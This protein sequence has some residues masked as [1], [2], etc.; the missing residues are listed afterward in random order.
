MQLQDKTLSTTITK[1]IIAPLY[2]TFIFVDSDYLLSSEGSSIS[3]SVLAALNLNKASGL[4]CG[5]NSHFFTA[6]L[7]AHIVLVNHHYP[8]PTPFLHTTFLELSLIYV[9]NQLF[10]TLLFSACFLL[11]LGKH[12]LMCFFFFSPMHSLAR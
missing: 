6:M 7:L 12:Q 11:P 5:K 2:C 1:T 4:K 8:D 9:C 3:S 10:I